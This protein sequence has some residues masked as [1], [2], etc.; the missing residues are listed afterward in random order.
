MYCSTHN[1]HNVLWITV[2]S[3]NVLNVFQAALS[4]SHVALRQYMFHLVKQVRPNATLRCILTAFQ[5]L[6]SEI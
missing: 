2:Y 3:H 5:S 1:A 4:S 6:H